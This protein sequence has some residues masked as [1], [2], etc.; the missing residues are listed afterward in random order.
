MGRAWQVV[1][2]LVILVLQLGF[3]HWWLARYR[4]GPM[5]W[6]WRAFT[7]RTTPRMRL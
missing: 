2:V 6:V 5:E 3:S 4:F 1:F 7:Y